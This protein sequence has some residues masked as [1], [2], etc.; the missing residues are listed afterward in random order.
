MFKYKKNSECV[1]ENENTKSL[2]ASDQLVIP[3][4]TYEKR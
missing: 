4:A 2:S 3:I 1:I